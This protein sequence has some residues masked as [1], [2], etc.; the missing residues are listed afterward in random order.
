MG[1][2]SPSLK[3]KALQ[4]LAR[5]E[6]SQAELLAKLRRHAADVE[7]RAQQNPLQ[8][9]SHSPSPDFS[10]N[11]LQNQS[12]DQAAQT[13]ASI[14]RTLE[15]LAASGLQSDE[16]TA[17]SVARTQGKRY[18]VHRLKQQ[19]KSKGLGAELIAQTVGDAKLTELARA[20][21]I[22]RRRFG[23]APKDKAETAR[24]VRFLSARG[25]D[26][27]VVRR[28]VRGVEEFD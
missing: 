16:R 24:Q 2:S 20:Q 9:S 17:Q 27:D 13:Q 23:D 6:H 12:S 22:W 8:R 28:V 26:A 1:F 10:A 25:F 3:G 14:T 4:C 18:G 11:D 19:L 15:E 7:R 21:D 5:R